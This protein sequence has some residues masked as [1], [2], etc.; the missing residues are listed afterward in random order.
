MGDVGEAF[1]ALR[2][3]RKEQRESNLEN[4]ENHCSAQCWTKH[5]KYHW[6]RDLNGYRLDFWPSKRKFMYKGKVM[7]GNV[8][9]FINKREK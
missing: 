7:T 8:T 6:A 2:Q 9:A 3:H 5:T 1:K 4:A